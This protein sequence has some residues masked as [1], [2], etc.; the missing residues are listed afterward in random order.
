M[1]CA[2]L[3]KKK[4]HQQKSLYPESKYDTL[5]FVFY[6]YIHVAVNQM[7][8]KRWKLFDIIC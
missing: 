2:T 4:S 1:N 3:Y 6:I 7:F 5:S 8:A